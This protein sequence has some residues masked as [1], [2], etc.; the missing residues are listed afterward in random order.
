MQ[1]VDKIWLTTANLKRN[2][3]MLPIDFMNYQEK[4]EAKTI[5]LSDEQTQAQIDKDVFGM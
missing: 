4:P 2:H 3:D 1:V 5:D